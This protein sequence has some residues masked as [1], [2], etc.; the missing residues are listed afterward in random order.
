MLYPVLQL[1]DMKQDII[2]LPLMSM[3]LIVNMYV[4]IYTYVRIFV[5]MLICV[6]VFILCSI[7][8]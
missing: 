1:I 6:C 5:C 7:L 3:Y 8:D 2:V 4:Y